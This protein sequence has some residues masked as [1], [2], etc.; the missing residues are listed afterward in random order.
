[1]KTSIRIL[2]YIFVAIMVGV[3]VYAYYDMITDL[4]NQKVEAM[5]E[6]NQIK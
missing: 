4:I 1:M 2:A 3:T 6:F 5:N